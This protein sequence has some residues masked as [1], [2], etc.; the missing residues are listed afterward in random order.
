LEKAS[1]ADRH[2][3]GILKAQIERQQAELREYKKRLSLQGPI[4]R[5]SSSSMSPSQNRS[6]SGSF[7]DN[8]QFDFVKFGS[9]SEGFPNASIG[10]PNDPRLTIEQTNVAVPGTARSLSQSSPSYPQSQAAQSMSPQDTPNSSAPFSLAPDSSLPVYHA[11]NVDEYSNLLPQSGLDGLFSPSLLKSANLDAFLSNTQPQASTT[12]ARTYTADNGGDTTAGLNRVFQFNGDGNASDTTSQSASP[13]SQ[14]NN[15]GITT[16]SCETSPEPYNDGPLH[17]NKSMPANSLTSP[18]HSV[19]SSYNSDSPNTLAN[20][21]VNLTPSFGNID[22]SVPSAAGFDPVLFGDYRESQAAVVGAGDF[23]GGFFDDALYSAPVDYSSP[24]TL[25]GILQSPQQIKLSP[26][27]TRA[28]MTGIPSSRSLMAEI[29][30]TRDGEESAASAQ[31]KFISCNKIW[32][33][34]HSQRFSGPRRSANTPFC[35]RSQL[36]NNPDFQDGKFDLDQLCSELRTKAKCSESGVMVPTEHVDKALRKLVN[37][38]TGSQAVQE[39]PY[40]T[41]QED[42]L[43]DFI[44]KFSS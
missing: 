9:Q 24:S 26:A 22:Y 36:Q 21:Q 40:L 43:D 17:K 16:S 42:S 28:S 34:I 33:D 8:F 12:E 29:E 31:S 1:E 38:D 2:E 14:W 13:N 25:F 32:Y 35:H 39:H 41:F 15:N 44:K 3:N 20:T 6:I 19:L 27:S 7:G 30:K 11:N 37:K 23:T 18:Q 10:S 4:K 5:S